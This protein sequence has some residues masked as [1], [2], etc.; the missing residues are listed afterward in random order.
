MTIVWRVTV[1]GEGA[2]RV[3]RIRKPHAK[4]RIEIAVKT[5]AITEIAQSNRWIE[6]SA[7]HAKLKKS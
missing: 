6:P 4:F 5:V 1:G 7:T 3:T 2:T